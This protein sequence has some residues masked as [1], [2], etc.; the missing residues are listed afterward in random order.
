MMSPRGSL[1]Y[2]LSCDLGTPAMSLGVT[3]PEAPQRASKGVVFTLIRAWS[4][5]PGF[6]EC[7]D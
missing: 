5:D 3:V 2:K 7:I 1:F 6:Y 4:L